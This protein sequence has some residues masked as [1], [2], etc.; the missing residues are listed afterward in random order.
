MAGA[1]VSPFTLERVLN[2]ALQGSQRI[3]KRHSYDTEKRE[4]MNRWAAHLGR[5][6]AGKGEE[7]VVEIGARRK[8]AR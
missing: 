3:Y 2:Q 1:G 8:T 7:K 6:L 4:A 5:I